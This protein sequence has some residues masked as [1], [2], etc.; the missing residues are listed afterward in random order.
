MEELGRSELFAGTTSGEW[1]DLIDRYRMVRFRDG[2]ALYTIGQ[3]VNNAY[4]LLEGKIVVEIPSGKSRKTVIATRIA[5]HVIGD[6]EIWSR[7]QA[8]ATA[9]AEGDVKAL[10]LSFNEYFEFLQRSHQLCINQIKLL[11]RH[12]Y[13]VTIDHRISV[14]GTPAQRVA[15]WLL[16]HHA[17]GSPVNKSMISENI[18]LS[19]RSVIQGFQNLVESGLI[20][21]K[22]RLARI[23]DRKKLFKFMTD[24]DRLT[25]S[26]RNS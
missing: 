8:L 18:G 21:E 14:L 3:T 2:Q 13:T 22:K 25:S 5:P 16:H 26:N 15:S 24:F 7:S 1:V 10:T 23:P 19:R 11:N 20:I 9:R 12:L 17:P 6:L 4:I